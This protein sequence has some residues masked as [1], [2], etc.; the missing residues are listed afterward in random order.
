ME[1]LRRSIC[2]IFNK[3]SNFTTTESNKKVSTFPRYD[4]TLKTVFIQSYG[5]NIK[6]CAVKAQKITRASI[7]S[8][9]P[10]IK[11]STVELQPEP[12]LPVDCLHY[13]SMYSTKYWHNITVILNV[14]IHITPVKRSSENLHCSS[15]TF[16]SN[17]FAIKDFTKVI[18]QLQELWYNNN[19]KAR[20]EV[21]ECSA[22]VFHSP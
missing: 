8:T 6:R 19:I 12:Y 21:V 18:Q 13:I 14:K 1:T 11:Y 5:A 4:H 10:K 2:F 20:Q 7:K 22:K 16:P 15:S 3:H 17:K 9:S